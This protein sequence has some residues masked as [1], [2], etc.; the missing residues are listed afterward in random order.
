MRD[1]KSN[2]YKSLEAVKKRIDW[3]AQAIKELESL[4]DHQMDKEDKIELIVLCGLFYSEFVTGVYTSAKLENLLSEIAST[5]SFEPF[6]KSKKNEFLF[7]LT[8][9]YKIGGHSVI[10]N[11]WIR[12]DREKKYSIVFTDSCLEE[13][14]EFLK[15]TVQESGG[16]LYFLKGNYCEKAKQLLDISQK[17]SKV[18]LMQHMYDPIPNLAY[19][20]P[21]WTTP[22]ILYNHANFK[23]SFGYSVSDAVLNLLNYDVEKTIYYRGV[24]KEK[25]FYLPFPNGGKM[26][27]KR[28]IN[29]KK[30]DKKGIDVVQYGINPNKKLVVSMGDGFKFS[31]IINYSFTDFVKA[32]VSQRDDVQYLVIGPNPDEKKWSELESETGGKARAVGY[33]ER[34]S[35][36]DIISSSDLYVA[37]FPMAAFGAAMAEEYDVPYLCLSVTDRGNE[38]YAHNAVITVEE[39]LDKSHEILNGEKEKYKGRYYKKILDRSDWCALWHDIADRVKVHTGQKIEPERFIRKEEIVN[40]QLMQENANVSVKT[41]LSKYKLTPQVV[42]KMLDIC[43][44]YDLH[45]MPEHLVLMDWD[46]YNK[47]MNISQYLS[48]WLQ[49]CLKGLKISECLEALGICTI[50]IYGMGQMGLNLYEELKDTHIKVECFIDKNA[51]ILHAP[52]KMIDLNRRP[53]N[54]FYIVNTAYVEEYQLRQEYACITD[55]FKIISLFELIDKIYEDVK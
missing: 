7:V 15:E 17:F 1:M 22:V 34:K 48:K 55:E 54:T 13:T 53:E 11:N 23:F 16:G 36:E 20:H 21:E 2:M 49:L 10:A 14:P 9:A 35:V 46:I 30:T 29:R 5:I 40:C 24:S 28:E 4:L 27:N 25:S 18:I 47:K 12:W 42:T 39:L 37:S 32:L 41:I 43:N 38:N 3:N 26:V 31:D 50:A 8:K 51:K 33:L 45:F 52:I 19:N 44:K 6:G